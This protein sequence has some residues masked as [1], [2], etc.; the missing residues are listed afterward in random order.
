M[1]AHVVVFPP[2]VK[3][4]NPYRAYLLG[5]IYVSSWPHWYDRREVQCF[6]ICTLVRSFFV[7]CRASEH[8]NLKFW[9][10]FENEWTDF[11]A[12]WHMCS[13]QWHET[14]NLWGHEVKGQDHTMPKRDLKAWRMHHSRHPLPR[15]THLVRQRALWVVYLRCC[16]EQMKRLTPASAAVTDTHFRSFAFRF[17]CTSAHWRAIL[18]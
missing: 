17:Y 4:C 8:N 2:C 18:I 9:T 16:C 15:L 7:C 10:Q 5:H 13:G 14:V 12:A 3:L 11:D 1:L 6:L